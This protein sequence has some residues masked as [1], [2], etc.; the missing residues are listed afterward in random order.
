MNTLFS[1]TL[2]ALELLQPNGHDHG[3]LASAIADVS[4]NEQVASELVVTAYRE[5]GLDP[6]AMGD[7]DMSCGLYQIKARGEECTRLKVDLAYASRRAFEELERSKKACA[8]YPEKQRFSFY[9][10]GSCELAP[11]MSADRYYLARWLRRKLSDP[12]A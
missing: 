11:R 2:A 9:I 6:N 10:S 12:A 7:E 5:S 1:F 4:P 3:P 8:S